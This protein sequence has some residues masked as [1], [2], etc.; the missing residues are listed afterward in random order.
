MKNILEKR[1][2]EIN[3]HLGSVL[4]KN[5]LKAKNSDGRT[6][7]F[8][9]IEADGWF[10]PVRI[11]FENRPGQE[12]SWQDAHLMIK[13]WGCR[14]LGDTGFVSWKNFDETR[15]EMQGENE[16]MFEWLAFVLEHHGVVPPVMGVPNCIVNANFGDL[17]E[18]VA[19]FAKDLKIEQHY[20]QYCASPLEVFKF[21]D[22]LDREVVIGMR[23][24]GV[25]KANVYIDGVFAEEFSQY[26]RIRLAEIVR[27]LT[28][29][30]QTPR[31]YRLGPLRHW[32]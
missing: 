2:S 20:M 21:K 32:D 29:D 4:E 26:D 17:H 24:R 3:A 6:I 22:G 27:G 11:E 30:I 18:V 14:E 15:H 7:E 9:P 12:P 23:L 13:L 31:G 1:I 19:P 25:E 8:V 5:G 10:S 16:K 28:V